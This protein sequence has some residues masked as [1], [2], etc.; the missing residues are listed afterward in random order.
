ML[1]QLGE[2]KTEVLS[3]HYPA[4]LEVVRSK[5]ARPILLLFLGW[6]Y[7]WGKKK[8]AGGG[9]RL[10]PPFEEVPSTLAF[11]GLLS[12]TC[13][14]AMARAIPHTHSMRATL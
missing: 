9:D 12:I 1:A 3:L 4:H 11:P 2:R 10:R 6:Y 5:L 13:L 8:N 14:T 7:S